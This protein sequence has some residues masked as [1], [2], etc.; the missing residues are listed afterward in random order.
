MMDIKKAAQKLKAIANIKR[1]EILFYLRDTELSVG[2]IEKKLKLS[3]SA[4]SQHLAVLRKAEIV[5][6]RRKAQSIFYRLEDGRIKQILSIFE[7]D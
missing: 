2:E 6:T 5:K 7:K 4:L 1:L 3:Q